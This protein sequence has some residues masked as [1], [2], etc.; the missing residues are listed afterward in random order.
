MS[1]GKHSR[2][3]TA[4]RLP[5]AVLVWLRGQAQQEGRPMTHIVIEALEAYRAGRIVPLSHDDQ[6]Q[7]T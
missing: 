2:G 4:F 1:P 5:E 3:Q 7:G 6:D